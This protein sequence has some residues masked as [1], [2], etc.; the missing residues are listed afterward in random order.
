MKN[1]DVAISDELLE[2]LRGVS[3]PTANQTLIGRGFSN[4]YPIGIDAVALEEGQVMVG[5]AKTLR[6]LPKREDLVKAQY[7]SISGR[8]HRDA[9]EAIKPNE[10][11]VIDAGGS[12]EAGVVGDMFTRRVQNLGGTGIIIDGVLRDLSAIKTVGLPVYSK[13]SHGSGIGRALMSVGMDE[14]I[15]IC[16]VPVIPGDVILGDSDGIV[17]IPPTE[18]EFVV[19]HC[20][21]HDIREKFTRLKLA[22]GFPLHRAYPPDEEL[23]K[24]YEEWRK[25]N[26]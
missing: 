5:R 3:V 22:E 1:P 6:F 15:Q 25:T 19:E 17:F 21:E 9:I 24:E 12:L 10:I 14:P 20:L 2:A 7:D 18:V 11:L 16:G 13:G 8:P 26:S 4:T 23:M